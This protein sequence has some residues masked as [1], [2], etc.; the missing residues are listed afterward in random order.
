EINVEDQPQL[1]GISLKNVIE[2]EQINERPQPIG[3]QHRFE[4]QQWYVWNDNQ[5]KLI[6]KEDDDQYLLFD[7]YNDPNE[8]EN[9][10][11]EHPK[12]VDRMKNELQN[13]LDSVN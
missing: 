6:Y 13:W 3:F 4:G 12:T 10:A 9:I 2:E 5:Y 7:L 1:D 8:T 11:G